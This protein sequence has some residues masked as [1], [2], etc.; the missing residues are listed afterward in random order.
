[1]Q[2]NKNRKLK[3]KSNLNDRKVLN[4]VIISI[5]DFMT[6]QV[7]K[8]EDTEHSLVSKVNKS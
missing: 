2:K 7:K 4:R 5:T 1:M 8:T 6:E 3:R